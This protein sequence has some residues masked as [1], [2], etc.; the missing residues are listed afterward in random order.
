M[1][2]TVPAILIAMLTACA[3]AAAQPL[4][5]G[6]VRVIVG[7]PRGSGADITARVIGVKFYEATGRQFDI[8]NRPGAGSNLAAA[9]AAGSPADGSTLFVGSVT[10]AI[11]AT[12]Y[13]KL[14]FDFTRDFAPVTLAIAEPHL[15]VAHASMPARS[16]K[17]LVALAR[18]RPGQVRFASAGT[19][20][21]THLAGELFGALAGVGMTHV[22]GK[23][24]SQALADLAA[25]ATDLM[26]PPA[27][28]ALSQVQGGRLRALAVTTA[29]RLASL[30]Q[31]PTVA[32][33][34][35]PGYEAA[36]WFG[37]LAPAQTPPA[38]VA[39]LHVEIVNALAQPDARS[40]FELQDFEILGG[41]P[42]RF[43][44]FIRA[45]TAKWAKV[46]KLS[47]AKAD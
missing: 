26:F 13:P 44:D 20:T 40:Q 16:V 15:L 25:G 31:L 14:P 38:I 37:F 22:P 24:G 3:G 18:S 35:L 36:T 41:N 27:S 10:N 21:V 43:A 1:R 7:Y 28:D 47:G 11:N 46:I 2:R 34:G 6:P 30:P 32:G 12:L 45:E 23:D 5:A 33:S 17:E 8:D 19:G 9:A 29:S 4:P 39:R 42:A